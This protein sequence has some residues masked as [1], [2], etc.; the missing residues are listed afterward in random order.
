MP[1]P[2]HSMKSRSTLLWASRCLGFGRVSSSQGGYTS[3]MK[4]ASPLTT[5]LKRSVAG[6]HGDDEIDALAAALA[7]IRPSVNVWRSQT[8]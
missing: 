6:L 1:C 5:R 7:A 2:A 3:L 8:R 4:V